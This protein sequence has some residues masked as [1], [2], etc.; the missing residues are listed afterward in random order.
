MFYEIPPMDLKSYIKNNE[1]LVEKRFETLVLD[2]DIPERL[3]EAM[4]YSLKA[5]GK[6][7]RP[8]LVIAGAEAVGGEAQAVLDVGI[9][10]EMI[11]T[12]S[13]IHDDLPAMDDD[14]LRRGK[15]TNHKV[16]GEAIA[17]LAGDALLADAF[18]LLSNSLKNLKGERGLGIISDIALATGSRGMTG[19]QVLDMESSGAITLESLERIHKYKTG[20]LIS[21]S[22]VS[23]AKCFTDDDEKIAALDEYGKSIGLAFQ[24][25]DDV[26]DIEGDQDKLGKDVGSDLANDKSTYPA[27]LGLDGSKKKARM[28]VEQALTSLSSFDE[29]ADPL[30][31]LAKYIIERDK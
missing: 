8:T 5:G 14:D 1:A 13:L 11:H 12:F 21:V 31:N 20:A 19:G 28:L 10:M 3:R 6:R 25:A 18:Y 2:E 22:V 4:N 7:L 26:L 23:G 16:F 9:V 24:I 30:R 27:I 29:K 17:I 15:P